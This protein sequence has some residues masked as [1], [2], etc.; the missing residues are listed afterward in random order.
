MA[1]GPNIELIFGASGELTDVAAS[2]ARVLDLDFERRNSMYLGGEY[3][4][5]ELVL[6][7]VIVQVNENLDELREPDYPDLPVIVRVDGPITI[8]APTV[9]AIAQLGLVAIRRNQW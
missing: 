8:E 2:V 4:R 1:D 5:A 6:G 7:T 9:V 3:Y